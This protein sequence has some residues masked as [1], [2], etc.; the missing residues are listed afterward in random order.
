MAF[1]LLT[2]RFANTKHFLL[3]L[4][5]G[6]INTLFGYAAFSLLLY[7]GLH[8]ALA[9]FIGAS[10]GILFNFNTTGKIVFSNNNHRLLIKFFLVYALI[11]LINVSLLKLMVIF[12]INLYLGSAV[13]LLPMAFLAYVLNKKFV[14][15]VNT[16]KVFP[17]MVKFDSTRQMPQSVVVACAFALLLLCYHLVFHGYFPNFQGKLGEDYSALLP[18]L[19]DGYFWFKTNSLFDVPWFTPSFCGGQ[20]YFADVQSVYYSIPQLLTVFFNP[21][22]SAYLSIILFAGIGFWGMYFLL[23][24]I[25]NIGEKSA[26]LAA[27]LF[28][29]NGFYAHRMLI[30]HFGFQGFMLVPFIAF[31]LLSVAP[32]N[33]EKSKF[34]SISKTVLAGLLVAYWLQSGLTSLIIPASL[35]VLIIACLHLINGGQWQ[36]FLYRGLGAILVALAL[37]ASKLVAGFA[38]MASFERSHYL[39]PGFKGLFIELKLLFITLFFPTADIENTAFANLIHMQWALTHHEWEYG[40]TFIPLLIILLAWMVGLWKQLHS[41]LT[42]TKPSAISWVAGGLLVMILILPIALNIYTPE[43]NAI[44]KQTPL[45][46]SSSTLFRWWLIY[47]PIVIVYAAICLE[48]LTFLGKYRTHT[49]VAG[50]VMIIVLNLIQDRMYYDMQGYDGNPILQAYQKTTLENTSPEIQAIGMNDQRNNALVSG[51]SQ[52]GCYNPSFG[53]SLENLPI[54]TLHPGSVFEQTDGYLN[55][56][57][58][59]CYVFPA[60]NHCQPG[61]HFT[62]A[63]KAEAQLFA[64][65]KPFSFAIPL[66]QKIAN[67]IT[68]LA[69][70]LVIGCLGFALM[71]YLKQIK[72]NRS[73]M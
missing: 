72:E 24:Q 31:L 40:V 5:V 57:N 12:A 54:K 11:Y 35:A 42:L 71:R 66:K 55:L 37:S 7:L 19:L 26:F 58:P 13:T 20:P 39:L 50:V 47:I 63:Q 38:F 17:I 34:S 68:Q 8:Y 45:I 32:V 73:I 52:L 64:H 29:F 22:T 23:R 21:L 60:E 46:K 9:S 1:S 30:G 69:L 18:A 49:V 27:S 33:T 51:V 53:Y 2:S 41:S 44:L 15:N 4:L 65:Y 61:D 14:F 25:F 28:M 36:V 10:A 3:Y 70:L 56:K 67:L 48:K 16:T 59:A 43:W 6:G 62:L